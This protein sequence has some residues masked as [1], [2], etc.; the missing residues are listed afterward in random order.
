MPSL[1][2]FHRKIAG[3]DKN[4]QCRPLSFVIHAP[5]SGHL[6]WTNLPIT[7]TGTP[8]KIEATSK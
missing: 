2:S 7:L 5:K 8:S 1:P 6:G 3:S 4:A